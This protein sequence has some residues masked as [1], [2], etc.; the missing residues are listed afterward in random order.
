MDFSRNRD[1][2]DTI[3]EKDGQGKPHEEDTWIKNERREEVKK[4]STEE[5]QVLVWSNRKLE[6]LMQDSAWRAGGT[7][8]G[9]WQ[10]SR[11]GRVE[12]ESEVTEI[13]R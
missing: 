3:I 5:T 10:W 4:G 11:A 2:V 9:Y 12:A 1:G 6:S 8:G 13:H 7:D